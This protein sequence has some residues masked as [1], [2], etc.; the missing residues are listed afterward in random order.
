M[1]FWM[2]LV[3]RTWS[4]C[5]CYDCGLRQ[6]VLRYQVVRLS[7]HR[8]TLEQKG[9]VQR[10]AEDLGKPCGHL[11]TTEVRETAMVGTCLVRIPLH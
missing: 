7:V 2:V 4:V 6:D 11:H 10:L 5:R 3:D 9:I 1:L 8:Q